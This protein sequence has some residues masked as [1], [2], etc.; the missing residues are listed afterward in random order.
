MAE[1]LAPD[2][3]QTQAPATPPPAAPPA[4]PPTPAAAPTGLTPTGASPST[5]PDIVDKIS[6]LSPSQRKY[7]F[8]QMS[9][10]Q[11]SR[12][13]SILQEKIAN[14]PPPPAKPGLAKRAQNYMDQVANT[15]P[16]TDAQ[17]KPLNGTG[18]DT[19]VGG[20]FERWG[21]GVVQGAESWV[22]HPIQTAHSAAELPIDALHATGWSFHGQLSDEEMQA[23]R[24]RLKAQYEYA[25]EN[26][27]QTLGQFMGADIV[28]GAGG[29][30]AKSVTRGAAEA[31][32]GGKG[33]AKT[34]V[35]SA[36]GATGDV[37][38]AGAKAIEDQ[39]DIE[40]K[41]VADQKT[42]DKKM[43]EATRLAAKND[44][45]AQVNWQQKTEAQKLQHANDLSENQAENEAEEKRVEGVNQQNLSEAQRKYQE[46]VQAAED[47]ESERGQL[48]RQ[49][50]QARLGLWRR[51]QAVAAD[52][53]SAVNGQYEDV[54]QGIKSA[55][56]T[57]KIVQP[58]WQTLGDTVEAG[59]S[60]LQAAEPQK[61]ALSLSGEPKITR[62]A[63]PSLAPLGNVVEDA[64]DSLQGTQT[65][66][67]IFESILKR[68]SEEGDLNSQRRAIMDA[69]GIEGTS[70]EDLDTHDKGLVDEAISLNKDMRKNGQAG[71]IDPVENGVP[72]ASWDHLSGYSSE[73]GKAMRED[74]LMDGD[75]EKAI[76]KVKSHID[77]MRQQMANKA[78]V[79]AKLRSA[80]KNWYTYRDVFHEN[81]GPSGSG[82]PVAKGL[83]AE[84]ATNATEPFLSKDTEIASRA[85]QMLVGQPFRG[86]GSYFDSGAGYLVD[87]LRDIRSRVEALPKPK[88]VGPMEQPKQV[89]AKTTPPP[90]APKPIPQPTPSAPNYPEP[91]DVRADAAPLNIADIKSEA[92]QRKIDSWKSLDK[93]Q[94][95]AL[96][97]ATGG[98]FAYFLGGKGR[99]LEGL[100]LGLAPM[101]MGAVADSPVF[102]EFA[103]APSPNDIAVLSR[104]KGAD[105]ITVQN[106]ITGQIEKLAQAGQTIKVSPQVQGFVGASNV[107][108]IGK[109]VLKAKQASSG[110]TG[111]QKVRAGMVAAGTLAARAGADAGAAAHSQRNQEITA[112]VSGHKLKIGD[113]VSHLG[114]TGKVTGTDPTGKLQVAWQ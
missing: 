95:R 100:G 114:H 47:T 73:L 97:S 86:P 11:R 58:P 84:D 83:K 90:E 51:I 48:A 34:L 1:V 43:D 46:N 26:P 85:R 66:I 71:D 104:L 67:P 98:V 4:V 33:V 87:R 72:T 18:Y 10:D 70:Y 68:A 53:K 75:I 106:Q 28:A 17:G 14:K 7:F 105:K 78:D 27:A 108:K 60:A 107:L 101:I 55:L 111:T 30:A 20:Q 96:L 21:Q 110:M 38:K 76:V 79:G 109:A 37:R 92:V 81:T 56:A 24:D 57:G 41:R 88:E 12:F 23:S 93:W 8:S 59:K 49:E 40:E 45:D 94:T 6:T 113:T 80:N 32:T 52:A 29:D 50:I 16:M 35:D 112:P 31:V 22:A 25:K 36:T 65:K 42:F 64:K 54:R 91:P 89:A 74:P 19:G 13:Q 61:K 77:A 5:E 99:V 2:P 39:T 102:R 63:N 3:T 44:H 103:S 62:R 9:D 82:S 69:R 15:P